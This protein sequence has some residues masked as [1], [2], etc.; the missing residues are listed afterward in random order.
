M[1]LFTDSYGEPCVIN[2]DY[3]AMAFR[4]RGK[5]ETTVLMTTGEQIVI[6]ESPEDIHAA[7]E[8][9][10]AI[11]AVEDN[12]ETCL[13]EDSDEDGPCHH[14]SVNNPDK[15]DSFWEPKEDDDAEDNEATGGDGEGDPEERVRV[16]GV[17]YSVPLSSIRGGQKND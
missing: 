1:L 13:Y 5:E 12:C 15:Q 7:A 17:P 8:G 4:A 10:V 6:Q 14:C 11:Y 9:Y 3:V 16:S 2:P